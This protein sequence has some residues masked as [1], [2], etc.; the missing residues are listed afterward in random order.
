MLRAARR[1]AWMLGQPV[2]FA[3]LGREHAPRPLVRELARCTGL[4]ELQAQNVQDQLEADTIR[5]VML[6]PTMWR[7]MAAYLWRR[8]GTASAYVCRRAALP[9]ARVLCCAESEE[10][11]AVLLE[12]VTSVLPRGRAAI[13]LLRAL[14]PAPS[15]AVGMLAMFGCQ[16]AAEPEASGPGASPRSVPALTLNQQPASAVASTFGSIDPDLLVLGWHRHSLPLPEP[17]LH[18]TA[19]RLSNSCPGD[20]LLVPVRDRRASG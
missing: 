18:R 4:Y 8:L 2:G 3:W 19:W 5:C 9:P 15:W 17:I 16:A 14:P 13:T 7:T 1:A 12:R 11:A 6:S 20:V 10:T